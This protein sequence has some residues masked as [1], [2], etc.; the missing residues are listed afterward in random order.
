MMYTEKS[1]MKR[2]M[3]LTTFE[4][5]KKRALK[6]PGMRR[7]MEE[8][9]SDPFIEAAYRLITL[10]KKKG[11]TQTE[12]ARKIGVSQQAVARL[13]SLDY[14]GHSLNSLHKIALAYG[15]RL[16]ISFVSA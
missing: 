7:A 14:K 8:A 16:Q 15:K 6:D 3:R 10:R 4:D 1:F 2:K 11:W 13:E 9:D 5:Y 12:L